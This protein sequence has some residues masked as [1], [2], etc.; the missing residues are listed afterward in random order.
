MFKIILVL[1]G[2]EDAAA[3]SIARAK[4]RNREEISADDLLVGC[5]QAISQFGIVQLGAWTLDL[6]DLGVDWLQQPERGGTKV[7]YS[8]EVVALFDQAAR[9]AKADGAAAIGVD[10]LLVAFS[11]ASSALMVEL[12]RTHGITSTGWRAAVARLGPEPKGTTPRGATET[13]EEESRAAEVRDYLT[14]EEAADVLGIHVQTLRGYVRSGK[15]QALRLAGE[16]AIRIRRAD[17]ET[18]LEPFVPQN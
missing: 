3:F 12:R 10:H 7:A 5:L 14:P 8:Q 9:I 11:G 15:L 18:V 6:E 13:K 1:N 4:A 16:R 17:L 2:I